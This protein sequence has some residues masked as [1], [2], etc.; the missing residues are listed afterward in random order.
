MTIELHQDNPNRE[1]IEWAYDTLVSLGFTLKNSI[2]EKVQDTPWSCVMRFITSQGI[3]YLKQTPEQL[4]LEAPITQI[5][6]NQFQA[7]VPEVIAHHTELNCFLMKD[8][9]RP[10]RAILR[11]RFDVK[12]FC[13]AM[14]Q[15]SLLQIAVADRIDA[16][17]DMGV[18]DWRLDKLPNLYMQLLSEK[19]ILLTDGLSEV[20]ID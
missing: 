20:D 17:L 2:P 1:S 8:A 6:Y 13:H 4:A 9:G 10:L 11:K 18:P 15:F 14:E 3:I 7:S 19:E 12:L 16:F 5:L